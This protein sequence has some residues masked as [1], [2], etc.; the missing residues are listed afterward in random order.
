MYVCGPT[1]YDEPHIGHLRSAY[2]FDV[3]RR[4][5]EYSGL[6]VKF[7]R[8][9]TDV[10]DKIIDKARE[11][12][13][14]D[15]LNETLK[16]SE[17]YLKL[18]KND[19]RAMGIQEPTVEPKATAHIQ[20]MQWLIAKLIESEKAYVS[21]GDVYYSVNGFKNYGQL[22][23]QDK[24]AM[25][26]NVRVDKN[27]KKR[28]PLD[29]AL[30]KKAKEGE[31]YWPSSWGNGR[32]GWHIE[33][34]AMSMKYLGKTF[35]IHGGGRD[36]IFPHHENEI[37]QSEAV[38]GSA[39]ARYWV[40]HGLITVEEKKMSKSLKNYITLTQVAASG[41]TGIEELKLLFLGTH[42]SA[43]LDYSLEK[44]RM[45]S[46]IFKRFSEFFFNVDLK[47][48]EG[49][50]G[51]AR[52]VETFQKIFRERMDDDF[53]TPDT[54]TWMHGLV[55]MAYKNQEPTEMISVATAISEV[56]EK[57]FGISFNRKAGDVNDSDL[58]L[59][60]AKRDQ[61]KKDKNFKLADQLRAEIKDKFS[62]ELIDSKDGTI[63]K[64][65]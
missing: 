54:M 26:E 36:L 22:S 32:P 27:E 50:K 37:A 58:K 8:N 59:A 47:L 31:P 23:Q 65:I 19:L 4:Y 3:M 44:M 60:I 46:S 52:S 61:A 14:A 11:S 38:T 48:K 30:W 2:V 20:D 18:Y 49:Y 41:A 21:D 45:E 39:F 13:A 9:V 35:D 10:D 57:V 17:K 1:V 34:S 15:L 62:V 29:F 42:Y 12:N 56:S 5:M 55:N 25:L 40:H 28:E 63:W 6:K 53:N 33:C 43:P 64:K 51:N 24:K 16:V 7:V